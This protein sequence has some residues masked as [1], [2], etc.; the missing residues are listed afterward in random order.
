MKNKN[1]SAIK[2]RHQQAIENFE[3]IFYAFSDKQFKEGLKKLNL[4]EGE[5][6]K[7]FK[8][9]SGSFIL[10]DRIK[11]LED[12]L[13]SNKKELRENLKDEKFLLDALRYELSNHEYSYSGDI[14]PALDALFLKLEDIPSEILR[15]AKRMASL[16]E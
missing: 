6:N 13:L 1:Y 15:E 4:S 12:L 2:R 14:Y 9:G 3:G 11:D 7:L 16:D 8:L 5:E 10:K